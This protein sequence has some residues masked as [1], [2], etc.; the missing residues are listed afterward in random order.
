MRA[1]MNYKS[2]L[3]IVRND[4][5]NEKYKY[6]SIMPTITEIAN[7][8]KVSRPTITKVYNTLE[9]EGYIQKRRGRGTIVKLKKEIKKNTFG[10]L[11]PGAG[12]SEIFSIINERFL[13]RSRQGMFDCLWEGIMANS[14]EI[15][16]EHIENCTD[17]YISENVNGIFFAPLERVSDATELNKKICRK[18]NDANI[19]II[20]IDRDIS[21]F[22]K[23][24]QFDLVSLD[25]FN[26]GYSMA[27]HLIKMGCKII[28]FF[29][30]PDSANSVKL[31]LYGIASA[32]WN[33]N[34][35]FGKE[36]AICGNPEDL[37]LI[38][39]IPFIPKKTGIICANDSTAAVLI[40]SLNSIGITV[41][42]DLLISGY[43]D[44][45]YAEHL[46]YT[47]T[48]YRQP[49]EE[50]A[51]ASISLMLRRIKNISSIPLTINITGEII[52]RESTKFQ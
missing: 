22:P 2:I 34:L 10:L 39:T 17:Y 49:C 52:I 8:Y 20:L 45:K 27:E 24:S 23:R 42:S 11:L 14:A 28:H 40:S 35:H 38:K 6:G 5:E 16:R 51:D 44:M 43:D 1:K 30:R 12:E 3:D 9:E 31:R 41:T 33:Y 13:T 26:A 19:P 4:I 15:R 29:Y 18:I 37:E 46:K 36:N 21:E 25:N 50:I 32:L 7:K 48:S 47:L